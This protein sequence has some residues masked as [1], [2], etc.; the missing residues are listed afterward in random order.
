[1]GCSC[2]DLGPFTYDPNT[3]P[4]TKFECDNWAESEYSKPGGWSISHH[5]RCKLYCSDETKP[6]TTVY[7][8]AGKWKGEPDRGFW[9]YNRPDEPGPSGING[10]WL[11]IFLKGSNQFLTCL[12]YVL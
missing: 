11:K 5:D 9:C 3:E 10:G 7:C 12:Q 4:H 2:P 8:E 6:V 1:M